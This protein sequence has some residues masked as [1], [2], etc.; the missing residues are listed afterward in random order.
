MATATKSE[1]NTSVK[2]KPLA[3]RVVCQRDEADETTSGG[4]VLP[5]SAKEKVNRAKVIAVGPGKLDE[6]GTRHPL[7]VQAGDH[8]L[9]N[10]YGGDEFEVDDI[11]Y[12][13]VRESDIL[14]VIED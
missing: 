6:N 2:L 11:K 13:I 5:D 12:T 9:L 8:V 7:S 1:T 3:D 14:A 10:K 4:I